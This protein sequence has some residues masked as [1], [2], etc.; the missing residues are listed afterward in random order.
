MSNYLL[1]LLGTSIL[2][3]SI[4]MGL[5]FGL[6]NSFG[7]HF[8][9]TIVNIVIFILLSLQVQYLS[10]MMLKSNSKMLF[11]NFNFVM[12]F[13]KILLGLTIV[14]VYK[15]KFKPTDINYVI[16][17]FILYMIFTVFEIYKLTQL[18]KKTNPI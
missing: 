11:S 10:N 9:F 2:A 17:F 4:T 1:H 13:V 15:V 5:V 18:A 8:N 12:S 6:P 3:L 14:I 16:I 7:N